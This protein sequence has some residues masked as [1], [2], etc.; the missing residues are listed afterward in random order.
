MVPSN[1]FLLHHD[2]RQRSYRRM[3]PRL[4]W[5]KPTAM[6]S[7]VRRP[8]WRSRPGPARIT[9]PFWARFPEA[10]QGN[11]AGIQGEPGI[12]EDSQYT[13]TKFDMGAPFFW[14][15]LRGSK[16]KDT[17]FEVPS[18]RTRHTSP[19]LVVLIF[20]DSQGM[21]ESLMNFPMHWI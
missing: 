8:P 9:R 1:I 20:S 4:G 11:Q 6:N 2:C 15:V 7:S 5:T 13:L 12:Q 17:I 19:C 16:R 21:R 3:V 14:L 10:F 18:K